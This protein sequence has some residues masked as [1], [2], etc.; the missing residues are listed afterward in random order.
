MG[1]GAWLRGHGGKMTPL[2]TPGVP[3]IEVKVTDDLGLSS[4]GEWTEWGVLRCRQH[5]LDQP[6]S[7]DSAQ[8]G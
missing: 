1:R 4:R 2:R 6:P 8:G 5:D 3:R 7:V